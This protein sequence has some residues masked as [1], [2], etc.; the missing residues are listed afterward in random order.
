MA[1]WL[2]L[3]QIFD[4]SITSPVPQTD[5]VCITALV[6]SWNMLTNTI[7]LH[8]DVNKLT[9]SFNNI[10]NKSILNSLKRDD[11]IQIYG[12]LIRNGRNISKL[13]AISIRVL[14]N[15]DINDYYKALELT[16]SYMTHVDR[17]VGAFRDIL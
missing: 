13:E 17:N 7:L 2:N 14:T 16:R 3:S 8:D 15:I 4:I 6:E 10:A 5:K 1:S 11:C 9:V 12:K